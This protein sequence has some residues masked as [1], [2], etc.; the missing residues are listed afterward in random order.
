MFT[1][2]GARCAQPTMLPEVTAPAAP[3]ECQRRQV[4]DARVGDRLRATTAG[5]SG[6]YTRS[7]DP[8]LHLALA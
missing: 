4:R 8:A 5:R 1:G 3:A 6:K 2:T 7:P